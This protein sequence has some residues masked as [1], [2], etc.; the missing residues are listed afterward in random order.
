VLLSPYSPGIFTANNQP[1]IVDS[2]GNLSGTSN[3]ATAG[4][5]IQIYCTGLGPVATPPP[6]G[7]SATGAS[8]TLTNPIV[9]IGGVQATVLSSSLV[10]GT[11]GEYQ[12]KVQVPAGI[13]PGSA[14]TLVLDMDGFVS[15]P[16]TIA[17][18]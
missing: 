12:L 11:V 18:K 14:V 15:N 13:T 7:S 16:V 8:P 3:P 10:P 2:S 5:V 17:V 6:T 9:V 1:V 4:S